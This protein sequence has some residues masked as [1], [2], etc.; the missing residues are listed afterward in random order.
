MQ[1]CA[2]IACMNEPRGG[3]LSRLA[4]GVRRLTYAR[5]FEPAL[6]R[7]RKRGSVFKSESRSGPA[8]WAA[9]YAGHLLVSGR[10]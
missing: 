8:E 7:F 3:H 5:R 1:G 10:R 6:V 9:I 2:P 4:P